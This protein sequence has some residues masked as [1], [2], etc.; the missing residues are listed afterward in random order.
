MGL[1]VVAGTEEWWPWG[2]SIGGDCVGT[3]RVLSLCSRSHSRW[4]KEVTLKV[5]GGGAPPRVPGSTWTGALVWTGAL[6]WA[7][8]LVWAKALV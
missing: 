6:G 5:E 4:E 2:L 3:L 7:G 1:V 8:A